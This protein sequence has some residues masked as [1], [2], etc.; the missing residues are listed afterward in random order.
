MGCYFFAHIN[1]FR[2]YGSFVST[3]A[4]INISKISSTI[5]ISKRAV[6]KHIANLRRSNILRRVGPTKGGKWEIVS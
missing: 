1:P 4:Y 2:T 6:E 3:N 5:G